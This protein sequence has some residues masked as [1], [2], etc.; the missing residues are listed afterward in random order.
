[1]TTSSGASVP[2][3]RGD[4]VAHAGRGGELHRRV[5]DAEALGAQA[6]LVDR[7]LAGDVGARP[8]PVRRA[9][10]PPAAAA[11]TCRCRDR[12]RPAAPSRRRARRRRRGRT[13]RCRSQRGGPA[14][15][16]EPDEVEVPAFAAARQAAT[17]RTGAGASSTMVF[18]APQVSQRP[19][20]SRDGAALL[21][22][23]ASDRPGHRSGSSRSLGTSRR[24]AASRCRRAGSCRDAATRPRAARPD[25]PA[26]L[27]ALLPRRRCG[28]CTSIVA[29]QRPSA[30]PNDRSSGPP[31]ARS[32]P[33]P[34]PR[35]GQQ[36]AAAVGQRVNDSFLARRAGKGN[37]DVVRTIDIGGAIGSATEACGQ[38]FRLAAAASA[39][40]DSISR[41][42]TFPLALTNSARIAV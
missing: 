41:S 18:Q 2:L 35:H 33:I 5:R 11:S 12:R 9:R 28:R 21:A 16:G 17:G 3:E 30:Q 27:S 24:R 4:D 6:H 40:A 26:L 10:R 36:H 7:L 14:S 1:M 15:A 22:D 42:C 13:R 39:S 31:S 29:D 20:I 38:S 23:E 34:G 32:R 37:D 8:L 25:R 19:P